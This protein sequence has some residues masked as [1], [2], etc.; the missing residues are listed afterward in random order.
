MRPIN[1]RASELAAVAGLNPYRSQAE[2][3]QE[4]FARAFGGKIAGARVVASREL[5]W[6][7]DAQTL[8]TAEAL[9]AVP[10]ALQKA[11]VAS[12]RTV[13]AA[14]AQK[15]QTRNE[16]EQSERRALAAKRTLDEAVCRA[17][18]A[19]A[20]A[21]RL[22]PVD[23][24]YESTREQAQ[25]AAQTACEATARASEEQTVASR[26]R[27]Q[28]EETIERAERAATAAKAA[29]T[30][31]VRA[32]LPT[33]QVEVVRQLETHALQAARDGD[34][35]KLDALPSHARPVVERY[36]RMAQGTV[37]ESAIVE[38]IR[39]ADEELRDV[40][41]SCEPP[42]FAKVPLKPLTRCRVDVWGVCDAY[43][44]R[45]VGGVLTRDMRA[46]VE[47]KNRR[48]RLFGR[49]P[50]YERVQ[51]EAYMRMYEVDRAA[52]VESFRGEERV[53]WLERDDALW[54]R[55]VDAAHQGLS[56][57]LERLEAET[58]TKT[59]ASAVRGLA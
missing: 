59:E 32:H 36:A 52:H 45:V 51:V 50:M 27:L 46:I 16:I 57:Q 21:A 58:R 25:V 34:A 38:R 42:L 9:A 44:P 39:D 29:E 3:V 17:T 33:M 49:V 12:K 22:D 24:G 14:R 31:A 15:A 4:V 37:N 6:L 54:G 53:T 18:D 11:R 43:C 41:P 10:P 30:Q 47:I 7:D 5:G 56:S 13:E 40:V 2:A 55:V 48:S 19:S 35:S 1:V 23:P 8:E 28:G 26:C 20:K